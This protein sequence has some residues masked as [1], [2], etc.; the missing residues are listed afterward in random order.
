MEVRKKT[1][2][3]LQPLS[4]SLILLYL[5]MGRLHSDPAALLVCVWGSD[6]QV[7]AAAVDTAGVRH[8]AVAYELHP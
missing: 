6:M 5:A 8:T 4:S 7:A 3:E 2:H 1:E